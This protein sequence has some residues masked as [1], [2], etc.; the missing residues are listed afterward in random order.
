ME[1]IS[2]I[3]WEREIPDHKTSGEMLDGFFT[4]IPRRSSPKPKRNFGEKFYN[5]MG[6]VKFRAHRIL[7]QRAKFHPS[8]NT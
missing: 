5:F 1:D 4:S 7:D 3:L 6:A 2:T 8:E